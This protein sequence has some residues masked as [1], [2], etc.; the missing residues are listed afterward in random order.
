MRYARVGKMLVCL[1]VLAAA[2]LANTNLGGEDL[3]ALAK[4]GKT[5]QLRELLDTGVFPDLAV[6]S[7]SGMTALN[8]GKRHRCHVWA[9]FSKVHGSCDL[10]LALLDAGACLA[11][12]RG[13]REAAAV[14]LEFHAD[15]NR[16]DSDGDTPLHTAAGKARQLF[17]SM[18][19]SST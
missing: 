16:P 11:C 5:A 2:V 14:L 10:A 6:D 9:N 4:S 12:M 18:F 1:P 13:D 17:F 7:K 19:C 8:Q 3:L 15:P